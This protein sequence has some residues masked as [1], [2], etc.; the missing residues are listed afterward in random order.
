MFKKEPKNNLERTELL[1][2]TLNTFT[3]IVLELAGT[4]ELK[5]IDKLES[6]GV[7]ALQLMASQVGKASYDLY[8]V[9]KVRRSYLR[10]D[11]V[12]KAMASI[13]TSTAEQV[14][15]TKTQRRIKEAIEKDAP[16]P[17][18]TTTKKAKK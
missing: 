3:E 14:E 9:A 4:T 16:K 1:Q 12:R 15:E 18:K 6:R 7:S 5:K 8:H 10:Q 13:D 17:Q 2:D 11:M